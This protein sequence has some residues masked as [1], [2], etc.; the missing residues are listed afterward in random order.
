ML[1]GTT[2]GMN[3]P[4]VT[5]G[6]YEL[7]GGGW[8]IFDNQTDAELHRNGK[9]YV[10]NATPMY[11]YQD[12][13]YVAYYAKSYLGKTYSNPVQ[14]SVSNYHDLK[15]VMDATEHHYYIDHSDAH[16]RGKRIPKIYINDYTADSANGLDLLKDLYDLTCSMLAAVTAYGALDTPENIRGANDLDFI[17]RTN[18]AAGSTPSWTPIGSGEDTCFGGNV[19]GDG[20]YVSGLTGSLFDKLCGNV[21]NLGAM[22]AF[23]TGGIANSGGGRAENCWVKDT[24]GVEMEITTPIIGISNPAEKQI[25][26]CYYLSAETGTP[27]GSRVAA[28]AKQFYNGEVAYNLNR[29]YL[30]KRYNLNRGGQTAIT[31]TAYVSSRYGNVDFIYADGEIPEDDDVRLDSE[32]GKYVPLYPDDYIFFGQTL[33]YG[34]VVGAKHQDVP[35]PLVKDGDYIETGLTGNRV[36]RAP[37]Y[38]RSSVKSKAFFNPYAVFAKHKNGDENTLVHDGMTAIDFT[39]YNDVFDGSTGEAKAYVNDNDSPSANFFAPLL[40]AETALTNFKNFG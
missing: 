30:Q 7:I 32:T 3:Q 17:L 35:S 6:A 31:D 2:V 12:G 25:Q 33:N 18:L 8:E 21:Y 29:F 10:N 11:Y 15:A 24:T 26:N 34:Y 20:H 19:H 4:R 9:E 37:A 23:T 14:F 13:Y 16:K 36:L 40:D 27:G 38:F 22:G 1:P 28:T 5:P 39:G